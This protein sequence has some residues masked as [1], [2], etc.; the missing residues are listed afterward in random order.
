[1]VANGAF[2]RHPRSFGDAGVNCEVDGKVANAGAIDGV[3]GK[4]NGVGEQR[5]T[6]VGR[7]S[8]ASG[9]GARGCM[10][11]GKRAGFEVDSNFQ[12]VLGGYP[13]H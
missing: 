1:M 7:S 9:A 4:A 5:R 6:S 12:H 10:A 2:K 11:E 3:S 13:D 8:V